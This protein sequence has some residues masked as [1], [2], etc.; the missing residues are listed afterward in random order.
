MECSAEINEQYPAPPSLSHIHTH[1]MCL[2]DAQNQ[3]SLAIP[4]LFHYMLQVIQNWLKGLGMRETNSAHMKQT[5]ANLSA[6]QCPVSPSWLVASDLPW[7]D[8]EHG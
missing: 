1:T 2:L 5:G 4:T 7:T 8:I 6:M 3:I